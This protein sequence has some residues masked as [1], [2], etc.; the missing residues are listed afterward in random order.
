MGALFD[1]ADRA[2]AQ[3][4]QGLVIQLTAIVVARARTRP[5]HHHNVN[6]LMNGSVS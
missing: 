6:L 4:F 3:L 1:L 2:E 5:D